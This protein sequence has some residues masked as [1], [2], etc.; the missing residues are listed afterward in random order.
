MSE[1]MNVESFNF[2]HEKVVA[3]YVRLVGVTQGKVDEIRKYDIRFCQPNQ[4]HMKMPALHSLEHMAAEFIRNHTD[5]V[6]D[7]GPMGC[8]TGFYLTVLNHD[9][10]EGILDILRKTLHDVLNAH[11]VP[12][13]NP[14]QC[15]WAVSHDL[16]GAKDLAKEMLAKQSEWTQVFVDDND[17][18]NY[19]S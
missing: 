12:A 5:V 13:C 14:K 10:Y 1:K 8:Q 16:Q 2:N 19:L 4:E 11:T 18:D 6:L 15:G 17:P 7:W 9:C 3:P